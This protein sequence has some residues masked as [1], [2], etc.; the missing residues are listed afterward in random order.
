MFACVK[1]KGTL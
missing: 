1:N